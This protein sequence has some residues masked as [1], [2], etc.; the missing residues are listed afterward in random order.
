MMY[1]V[2]GYYSLKR[3]KVTE[4]INQQVTQQQLTAISPHTKI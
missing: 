3:K 1:D 4:L 2:I